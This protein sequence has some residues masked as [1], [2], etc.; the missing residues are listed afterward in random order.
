MIS[1]N[2]STMQALL[3]A[4]EMIQKARV[5]ISSSKLA[6]GILRA[7]RAG[8]PVEVLPTELY[9]REKRS[10]AE[11][12]IF[13]KL[14]LYQ[15]NKVFLAGFMKIL[16]P[17]FVEKVGAGS[18]VNIHPSK[19]PLF[20]GARGFEETIESGAAYGGI[21]IHEVTSQVDE[22]RIILQRD[23]EIPKSRD[24]KTSRLWLSINEQRVIR[25]SLRR[26]QCAQSI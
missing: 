15:I 2:G 1:G 7:R 24:L 6:Y 22:G 5:I 11:T 14:K 17:D 12:W 19:L 25:E 18:I 21:T 20:K 4:P 13:E 9:T 8:I 3:D 10:E 16:S 26:V 23:I